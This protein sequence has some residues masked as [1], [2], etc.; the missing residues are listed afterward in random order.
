MAEVE[1]RDRVRSESLGDR[2]N[3]RVHQSEREGFVAPANPM[4]LC[5]VGFLS[6]FDR[7]RARRQICEECLLRPAA[8]MGSKEVIDFRKNCPGEEPG[9][10]FRF[11]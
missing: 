6:P 5:E 10:R 4:S 8:D 9:L 3:N 1:R 7:Q 2:H 11:E